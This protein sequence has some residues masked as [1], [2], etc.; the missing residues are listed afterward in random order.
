MVDSSN[1]GQFKGDKMDT[2][3]DSAPQVVEVK[4]PR[5]G[6]SDK[7]KKRNPYGPRKAKITEKVGE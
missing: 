4:K 1:V 2:N 5:K 3:T 6:R 7:G